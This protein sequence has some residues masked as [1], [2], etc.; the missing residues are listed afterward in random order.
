MIALNISFPLLYFQPHTLIAS[1]C[2]TLLLLQAAAIA[3]EKKST[4]ATFIQL[5]ILTLLSNYIGLLLIHLPIQTGITIPFLLPFPPPPFILPL[6][7]L[8]LSLLLPGLLN[9]FLCKKV[10]SFPF[11]TASLVGSA[12]SL[13]SIGM[14]IATSLHLAAK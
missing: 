11:T 4:K 3:K 10:L 14:L 9:T 12:T 6:K 2:L 5:L 1:S 7:D 13:G 8:L